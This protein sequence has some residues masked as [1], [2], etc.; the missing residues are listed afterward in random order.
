MVDV[1]DVHGSSLLYAMLLFTVAAERSCP[2]YRRCFHQPGCGTSGI[3][4]GCEQY[5]RSRMITTII[6]KLAGHEAHFSLGPAWKDE[7][8][9]RLCTPM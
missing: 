5:A 1:D 3:K 2:R 4:N 6:T 9:L 8:R 7:I